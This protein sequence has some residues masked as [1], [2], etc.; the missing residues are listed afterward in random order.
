[1]ASNDIFSANTSS[2][3]LGSLLD[4]LAEKFKRD[5]PLLEGIVTEVNNKEVLINIGSENQLRP[6]LHLLCYRMGMKM[7][8]PVTG[9]IVGAEAEILGDL[10]VKEV[11][12]DFSKTIRSKPKGEVKMFDQVIAR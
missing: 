4:S 11:F 12:K 2:S 6:N 7:K 5:F 3:S 8:H 9:K 1:M 10:I